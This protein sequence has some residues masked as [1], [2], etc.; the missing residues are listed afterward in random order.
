MAATVTPNIICAGCD[1]QVGPSP[2]AA[3]EEAY[4]VGCGH[5]VC[6]ACVDSAV[7]DFFENEDNP[8]LT[9]VCLRCGDNVMREPCTRLFFSAVDLTAGGDTPQLVFLRE[10]EARLSAEAAKLFEQ[11]S[12]ELDEC[13]VVEDRLNSLRGFQAMSDSL[14]QRRID[15]AE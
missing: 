12:T 5:V 2:P 1:G 10:E 11:V 6:K 8:P 13:S 3:N 4:L 9:V 7:L 14:K 15:G